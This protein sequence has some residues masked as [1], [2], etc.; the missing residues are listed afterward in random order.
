MI[1]V[2]GH[3]VPEQAVQFE[4]ER[5]MRFYA[6]HGVPEAKIA[7]DN[8]LRHGRHEADQLISQVPQLQALRDVRGL[9]GG[10]FGGG[11]SPAKPAPRRR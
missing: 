11:L 9:G 6:E 10:G 1:K 2:N 5:L 8:A 3:Q 7:V 4:L